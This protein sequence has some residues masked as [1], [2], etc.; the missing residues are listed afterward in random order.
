MELDQILEALAAG[1]T[2]P[3]ADLTNLASELGETESTLKASIKE[4]AANHSSLDDLV[5]MKGE[6]DNV[7]KALAT[8]TEAQATAQAAIDAIVADV[9]GSDT[10]TP[11]EDEPAE[12]EAE[13]KT[14]V[15]V[16]ASIKASVARARASRAAVVTERPS[17][18]TNVTTTFSLNGK[19][20]D[21]ITS[22]EIGQA[23]EDTARKFGGSK[24]AVLSMKTELHPDRNLNGDASANER[25]LL[26]LF[27][28]NPIVPVNAAGGCCSI[29]EPIYDQPL[30][31]SL[32]RPIRAAFDVLQASRGAVQ[33]YPPVCMPD[34][35]A[36]IWTCAQDEAVDE[37]DPD[38]WKSCAEVACDTPDPVLVEPIFQCL[39]IGE[40]QRRYAREQWEA[41]LF[42][43]D[44][45][46]ARLAEARLFNWLAASA[47][48]VYDQPITT[49]STYANFIKQQI[50]IA[51]AMRIEQRL[52]DAQIVTVGSNLI[53]GAIA[54]DSLTRRLNEADEVEFLKARVNSVLAEF[55]I[56]YVGSDDV[57]AM[58]DA[59]SYSGTFP[60]YPDELPMVT[61]PAGS[62]K[63]LD[64]GEKNLGI[65][66]SDISLARQNK[67]ASFSEFWEGLLV[68]NC[69][70]VFSTVAVE[71]CD[72]ICPGA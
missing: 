68:R 7:V 60:A 15:P 44:K 12:D 46:A 17:D 13:D 22:A 18:L 63:V 24:T 5:A 41:H 29:P 42:Q 53:Y 65:I 16:A 58:A 64:G 66:E 6:Y 47:T 33:T 14:V 23:F 32:D 25:K 38:T 52:G 39:T 26:D 72:L 55:G 61:L 69:N 2:V 37:D 8:V 20:R 62:A 11:V 21:T 54:E 48:A 19:D 71:D 43:T 70:V 31:G 1:E 34:E 57:A 4:A 56:T 59:F 9:S 36:A 35:G 49:G 10:E 27:G 30:I 45:L 28:T 50:R 3:V 51:E 67:V 40:F